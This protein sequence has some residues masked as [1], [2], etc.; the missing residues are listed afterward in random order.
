MKTL[1]VFGFTCLLVIT[2]IL[3]GMSYSNARPGDLSCSSPKFIVQGHGNQIK[4]RGSSQFSAK[5]QRD[6]IKLSFTSSPN[7]IAGGFTANFFETD[8]FSKSFESTLNLD[9]SQLS[10]GGYK[11]EI[12]ATDE[13]GKSTVCRNAFS[14][15]PVLTITSLT[16]S[17]NPVTAGDI[18]TITS[19]ISKTGPSLQYSWS[20]NAGNIGS[21]KGTDKPQLVVDLDPFGRG[22]PPV[23][24]FKLQVTDEI[25]QIATKTVDVMTV[26]NPPPTINSL[27]AVP[28][29]AHSGE[30]IKIH[31]EFSEDVKS[32]SWEQIAGP[33][34]SIKTPTKNDATFVA[35][36]V[37]QQTTLTFKLIVKDDITHEDTRTIDIV[38]I[39]SN[40]PPQAQGQP[41]TTLEGSPKAITLSA[42]D[43]DAGD[44]LTF[45]IVNGP[46]HG[47]LSPI[48]SQGKTTYTPTS[49]FSGSDSFTFKATDNHGA[50]SNVA[51]VSLT[52][53]PLNNHPQA[54]GQ[55]VTIQLDTPKEI[56]LGASDP[57]PS[58]TLTFSI[59]NGPQHGSLSPIDSQGK[60]TYTPT[61][62][63]SGSD[64]FTFKAT[65]NH[66]ADSNVA[67]IS[68]TV[69]ATN[70]P[71]VAEDEEFF[72]HRF[73][74]IIHLSAIEPDPEDTLTF[75]IV[76]Q[77]QH[78]TLGTPTSAGA[79]A[80][81]VQYT[82]ND[83]Q[84]IGP[85]SFTWKVTDNHGAESNIATATV[86]IFGE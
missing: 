58:D 56:T 79:G 86:H 59:V 19:T 3:S 60:T 25:G 10:V 78:L 29:P 80:G 55:S 7:S 30:K 47:S 81:E 84:Y 72:I 41:V 8:P 33:T 75:T 45:S 34:V 50:D 39:P 24:T 51:T 32:V 77:P 9:T 48:D 49:G 82:K 21:K 40:N 53:Q 71:P 23:V 27:Q 18:L 26:P 37:T 42:S 73:S 63:F 70:N 22:L 57:D 69:G 17:K 64:S 52:V 15:V 62:G 4:I 14:I 74:D 5:D 44:T 2:L 54:Q 83:I 35:P 11:V 67:E 20:W 16:P 12:T 85:D 76:S 1:Q 36:K 43:P 65:D 68:L 66:G 38:V 13:D 31:S 6:R 46:Q 61:S 28:N